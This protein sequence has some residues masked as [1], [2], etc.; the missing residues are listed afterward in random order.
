MWTHDRSK[1]YYI[2]FN[3]IEN[4]TI[5]WARGLSSFKFININI[6]WIQRKTTYGTY[7]Q[8]IREYDKSTLLLEI[9]ECD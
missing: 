4:V 3:L 1:S 6:F 9:E 8:W 5:E 7:V 2:S